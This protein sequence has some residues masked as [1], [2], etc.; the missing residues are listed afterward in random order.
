[1]RRRHQSQ[2]SLTLH[3]IYMSVPAGS[4]P[5]DRADSRGH[6]P[7]NASDLPRRDHFARTQRG[8]EPS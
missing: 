2:L 7:R 8:M 6:R 1:M 4:R 5:P 3:V